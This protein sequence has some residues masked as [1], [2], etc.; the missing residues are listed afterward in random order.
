MC[1][2][3]TLNDSLEAIALGLDTVN[4]AIYKR[5]PPA[6]PSKFSSPAHRQTQVDLNTRT[7]SLPPQLSTTSC[8]LTHSVFHIATLPQSQIL[9][10]ATPTTPNSAS[11][12]RK[13]RCLTTLP[14][15]PLATGHRHH[16]RKWRC[17]P[18]RKHHSLRRRY[19]RSLK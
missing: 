2:F 7:S 10:N 13:L 11:P 8:R 9:L 14:Q 15:P 1:I 12:N 16:N 19:H 18:P 3:S 5:H 17:Q 4:V 6:R